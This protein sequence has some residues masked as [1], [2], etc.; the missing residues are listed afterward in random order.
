MCEGTDFHMPSLSA[1]LALREHCGG[2]GM[3][4]VAGNQNLHTKEIL[5]GH[6]WYLLPI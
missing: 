4:I 5:F 2:P 1:H 6:L 3:F